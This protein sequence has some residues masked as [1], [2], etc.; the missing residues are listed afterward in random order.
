MVGQGG[1]VA[2]CGAACLQDQIARHEALPAALAAY[3]AAQRPE[4]ASAAANSAGRKEG[5]GPKAPIAVPETSVFSPA[6]AKRQTL[7][8]GKDAAMQYGGKSTPVL[9]VSTAA[10]RV[11]HPKAAEPAPPEWGEWLRP[12]PGKGV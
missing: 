11:S 1:S 5:G 7:A 3:T 12:P 10:G 8:S 6:T 4:V 2:L 9:G